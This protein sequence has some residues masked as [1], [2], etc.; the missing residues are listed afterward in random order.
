MCQYNL[1]SYVSHGVCLIVNNF[2]LKKNEF[3]HES[4]TRLLVSHTNKGHRWSFVVRE[5][6]G[7]EVSFHRS[8]NKMIH[9]VPLTCSKAVL[10]L[11]NAPA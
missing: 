5:K 2:H 11:R 4:T 6:S 3:L 9:N 10:L 1:L 8:T 7:S